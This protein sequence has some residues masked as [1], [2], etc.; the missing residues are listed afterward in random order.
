MIVVYVG[1]YFL[2][3]LNSMN[4]F[5]IKVLINLEYSPEFVY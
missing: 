3:I 2:K 1:I 5:Q 4:E